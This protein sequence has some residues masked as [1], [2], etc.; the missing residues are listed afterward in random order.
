L[1]GGPHDRPVPAHNHYEIGLF[2]PPRAPL[3]TTVR[4]LAVVEDLKPF[5]LEEGYDLLGDRR[6]SSE[7]GLVATPTREIFNE[8]HP[9]FKKLDYTTH[10]IPLSF[11]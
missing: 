2:R 7:L 11:K 3:Y 4:C 9:V 8:L 1:L 10:Y 6:G 5:P